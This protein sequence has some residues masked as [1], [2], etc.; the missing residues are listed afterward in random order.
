MR[1]RGDYK[2]VRVQKRHGRIA[3]EMYRESAD[4]H[5]R[6]PRRGGFVLKLLSQE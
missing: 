4:S 1:N 3:G 6:R 5:K 2:V